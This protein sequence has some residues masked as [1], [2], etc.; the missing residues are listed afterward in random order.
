MYFI[1]YQITNKITRAFYIGVHKTSNLNDGYMGSGKLI[2]RAIKKY[3]KDNFTKQIIEHFNSEE[4]MLKRESEIVTKQ[5]I[6]QNNVYNL[7]PGGGYGDKEKNG[8]TFEGHNHSET[9]KQKIREKSINRKHSIETRI[10]ISINN[11]SKKDPDRHREIV[12]RA[13]SK[14][15]TEEHRKKISESI[16]RITLD[17]NY[18][19]HN[20]GLI[21]DKVKCPTC[22]KEGAKNVM[23]RW[24][25]DNCKNKSLL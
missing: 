2:R 22:G 13:G 24:H 10:K 15:K 12:K 17:K 20:K 14:N 1:L 11:F 19:S 16:K 18:I 5:F 7:M 6:K 9:S 4:E 25:F 21:R 3:G 23:I 8:L